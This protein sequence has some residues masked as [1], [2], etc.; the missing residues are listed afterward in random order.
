MPSSQ[1]SGGLPWQR[2][3]LILRMFPNVCPTWTRRI[4]SPSSVS[5]LKTWMQLFMGLSDATA[6]PGLWWELHLAISLDRSWRGRTCLP[7]VWLQL[8]P[9]LDSPGSAVRSPPNADSNISWPI[10]TLILV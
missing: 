3:Y 7:P 1:E 10:T 9:R 5:G 8:S 4:F 2:A 6:S